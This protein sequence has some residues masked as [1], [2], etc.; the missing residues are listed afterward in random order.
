MTT[1]NIQIHP[2]A[3]VHKDAQLASGVI[4]GPHCVVESGASIGENTILYANV[5]IGKD[6]KIGKN[7]KFFPH[8]NATII[9]KISLSYFTF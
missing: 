7:N 3:V 6:V 8:R 4:I 9:A 1:Q 2:S 5:V